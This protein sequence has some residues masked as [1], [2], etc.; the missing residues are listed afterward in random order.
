VDFEFSWMTYF[1]SLFALMG[2]SLALTWLCRTGGKPD[3]PPPADVAD[4]HKRSAH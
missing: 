4:E 2:L 3:D 1:V